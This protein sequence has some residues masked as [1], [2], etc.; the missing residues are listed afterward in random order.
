MKGV[1][2][3]LEAILALSAKHEETHEE[4]QYS[5]YAVWNRTGYL[6]SASQTAVL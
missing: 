6:T 3:L 1:H 5:R 4:T 2:S